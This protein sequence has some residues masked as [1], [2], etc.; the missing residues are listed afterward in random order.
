MPLSGFDTGEKYDKSRHV[1]VHGTHADSGPGSRARKLPRSHVDPVPRK[2][3]E[4]VT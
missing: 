4:E 3:G 1:R 2:E